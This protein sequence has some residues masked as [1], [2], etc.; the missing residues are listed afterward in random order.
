MNNICTF[1]SIAQKVVSDIGE[2]FTMDF[3]KLEIPGEYYLEIDSRRTENF[4]ID[5]NPFQEAIWKSMNFLRLLRCGEDVAG[6]HSACHLNCR[7]KHEDGRSVP[8]FG[9]WHDAGDVSQYEICTAEMANAILD[10]AEKVKN[11]DGELYNRLLEEAK[12][13]INWLLRTRFGDGSRVLGV[14]YSI[15]R[16]NVLDP[17][18]E[19]IYRGTAENGPFENFCAAV[20][21]V[22]SYRL[23]KDEDIVFA[24]WCLRAAKED[25]E[26]GR[27]GYKKGIF[28]RRWGPSIVSQVCG[29]GALAAAELYQITKDEKYLTVGSE[30]ADEVLSCQ[31]Q[32]LPDWEKPLRGFFYED[33][34]HEY[35]LSYEHRGHEQTPIQ[36]LVRLC[37]VAPHHANYKKWKNGLELYAEY[38]LNTCD[39]VEPYGLLPGHVYDI[40]KINIDHFTVVPTV[41]S[42]AKAMEMV[43]GQ[44]KAG[45][46][47]DKDVFLRRFPIA[48]TRR[49]FHATLLSKVKAVSMLANILKNDKL[50]QVAIDQI[51]WILGKNPFSSSTMYGEGYNYHPLYVAFSGQMVGALP[52]GIKT[53]G[54]A[55]VPYWPTIN[56]AVYKEIWG[57]TTGKLLWVLAD[58]VK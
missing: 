7:T 35:I 20:A 15:W 16:D 23:F 27:L 30:Y 8:N 48:V 25:F 47:L 52:V 36:G 39:L 34:K 38:I 54:D 10:L 40:N 11:S 24:E 1:E 13:G 29:D 32:D 31:Q 22:V 2:F 42:T 5:K 6:V 44:V 33:P 50:K 43:K 57:H 46:R 19:T 41:E 14:G 12:V 26:F 55:D 21:E 37:E 28:T 4:I 53:L 49:G 51:E 17:Q 56:N 9:G 45:I 58:L 3:S 18:N